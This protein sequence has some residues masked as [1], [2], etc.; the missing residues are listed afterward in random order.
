MFFALNHLLFF[1]RGQVPL[2]AYL[3][4]LDEVPAV[5]ARNGT[6]LRAH[7]DL[8]DGDCRAL[9]GAGR[10]QPLTRCSAAAT[11]IRC[12]A[13]A[14]TWTEAPGRRARSS[15]PACGPGARRPAA[16]TGTPPPSR[17]TRTRV[18]GSY[19]ASLAGFGP[20]DHAP[21]APRVLPRRSRCVSLP[22]QF[23]PLAMVWRSK[24]REARDGPQRVRGLA[25]GVGWT[26]Q[27]RRASG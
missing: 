26:T 25:D 19:V 22:A 21:A 18:I 7:N 20:R 9:A 15:W 11:R 3:A 6:M 23:L 14:R 5:E 24:R 17:A 10:P 27:L 13:S 2:D 16:P 4:L 1:Y 12:A 8:V